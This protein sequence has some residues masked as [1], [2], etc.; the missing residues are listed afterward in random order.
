MS[1]VS[2][3]HDEGIILWHKE[4]GARELLEQLCADFSSSH[5]VKV[6]V[7]YIP[8]DQIKQNLLKAAT[9][10]QMPDV[11]LVPS[12]FVGLYQE[13]SLAAVP[14]EL[15]NASIESIYLESIE[16]AG[17]FYGAPI[18]GGNHLLLF[19]NKQFVTQ[20]AQT[21]DALLE[22]K[23]AI[24]AQGVQVIGWNYPE[25]YWF[26]PFLGAFGGWPLEGET[27]RLNSPAMHQAL[28]F[29]KSL[30]DQGLVPQNCTY[31]CSLSR[32]MAGDF[33]YAI[34]GDWAYAEIEQAL[35]DKLGVAVLPAIGEK[36]L[37]PMFSSHALLFP[38]HSLH[39]PKAALLQKF[40]FFMQDAEPQGRWYEVAQRIPVEGEI[41]KE[42]KKKACERQ[43]EV[44]KQLEYARPMPNHPVMAFVWEAMR[45]GFLLFLTGSVDEKTASQYMQDLAE[46][47]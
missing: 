5:Q 40:L 39:G 12:D 45:K 16:Y 31:D 22:Q 20:A 29:Y 21:W 43:V 17:T 38:N 10:K 47:R 32:F 24:E 1:H 7:E 11:V 6:R 36:P 3:A 44:F 28:R 2:F 15:Q 18:L 23:T 27:I 9:R 25:M 33:A 37:V 46:Q 4:T 42:I 14:P 34:N 19:Y 30:A 13:L 26:I 35:G 41:L 8:H